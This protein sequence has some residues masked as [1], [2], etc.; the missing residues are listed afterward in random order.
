MGSSSMSPLGVITYHLSLRHPWQKVLRF[1]PTHIFIYAPSPPVLKFLPCVYLTD[2]LF[3]DVFVSGSDTSI[4][5]KR[6]LA[7]SDAH[8]WSLLAMWWG[9]RGD[10][11]NTFPALNWNGNIGR[12]LGWNI[13]TGNVINQRRLWSAFHIL[14]SLSQSLNPVTIIL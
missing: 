2:G 3:W 14:I 10:K 4:G 1:A 6:Q 7:P 11:P 12:R 8:R 13:E 9:H 5:M